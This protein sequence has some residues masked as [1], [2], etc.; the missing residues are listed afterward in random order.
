MS[1]LVI[2]VGS[3]SVRVLL[4]DNAAEPIADASVRQLIRFSRHAA[5]DAEHLRKLT[6][7]CIDQILTHPAAADIAA[8]GMATFVGNLLG[9]DAEGAPVTP[10]RYAR[11]VCG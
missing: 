9:V 11:P 3:S 1:T 10:T 4:F 6:E 2:D 7:Q 8:V 5:A